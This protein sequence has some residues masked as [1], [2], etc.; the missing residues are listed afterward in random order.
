MERPG[1]EGA[2]RMVAGR[3]EILGPLGRGGM[4]HVHLAF[5]RALGRRVALKAAPVPGPTDGRV[6][7]RLRREAR[8]VAMLG[9]PNVVAVHD[10]VIDA[11]TA[12]IVMELV[13]GAPLSATLPGVAFPPVR[14]VEVAGEVASALA[15]AH[16]AG[17]VHGDVS[18]SNVMLTPAGRAK[19]LDFGIARAVPLT[20]PTDPRSAFGTL[21][22]VAPEQVRGGPVDARS[23]VYSLGALLFLMLTGRPPFT[24]DAASVMHAHLHSEPPRPSALAPAVPPELD[25]L[26]ARCLAKDPARRPQRAE[27]V[28][29]ELWSIHAGLA[30][31]PRQ[32]ASRDVATAPVAPGAWTTELRAG[33]G[34]S[35]GRR[36]RWSWIAAVAAGLVVVLAGVALMAWMLWPRPAPARP[37]PARPRAR[38]TTPPPL[39]APA[40]L[41]A[42]GRCDGFLAYRSTLTWRA[43]ASYPVDGY[44]VYRAPRPE[45]P[46]RVIGVVAGRSS[47]VYQDH[48]LGSSTDYYYV[49]RATAGGRVGPPSGVALAS[50]PFVCLS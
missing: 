41:R 9:H 37:G 27:D 14:A 47:T 43:P 35:R 46:Y 28:E 26:V 45:G 3:F 20:P 11:G 21:E 16:A 18:P 13:P 38:P 1:P 36:R 32:D 49:I 31:P 30:G 22:Y 34:P 40:A 10:V 29:S 5:D 24:G 4:G 15:H 8:V 12:F 2:G 23:D 7:S 42:K 44:R 39:L 6:V 25:D 33:E 19:V 48:D 17:V 50:T